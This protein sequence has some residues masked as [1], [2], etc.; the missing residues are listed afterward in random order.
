MSNVKVRK[1]G[2]YLCRHFEDGGLS[3]ETVTNNE[4]Y[5]GGEYY[6]FED[7]HI[8][9]IADEPLDL[10]SIRLIHEADYDCT[11]NDGRS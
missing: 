11:C 10:E 4:L 5:I 2:Y 3:I 1:G 9:W 8:H 7:I 6:S